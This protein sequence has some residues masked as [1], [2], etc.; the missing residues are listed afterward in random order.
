MTNTCPLATSVAVIVA[1]VSSAA[2]AAGLGAG[3]TVWRY[4]RK[5]RQDGS[6]QQR[7]PVE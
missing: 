4:R 5:R 6:A 1:L 2:P 7:K 3:L